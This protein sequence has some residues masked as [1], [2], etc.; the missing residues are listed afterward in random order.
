MTKTASNSTTSKITLDIPYS[1]TNTN[2]N[3]PIVLSH[4]LSVSSAKTGKITFS[5]EITIPVITSVNKETNPIILYLDELTSSTG[6]RIY[7][8]YV[9]KIETVTPDEKAYYEFV[10]NNFII[11]SSNEN[12]LKIHSVIPNYS[13]NSFEINLDALGTGTCRSDFDF[14]YKTRICD[15]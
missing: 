5:T 1:S 11:R 14:T 12:I 4:E 15:K 8:K 10:L 3:E 7:G 2:T 13:D 6:S 9:G